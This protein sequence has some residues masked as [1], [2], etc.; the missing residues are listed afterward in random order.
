MI[1]LQEGSGT[2]GRLRCELGFDISEKVAFSEFHQI[3]GKLEENA[4]EDGGYLSDDLKRLRAFFLMIS[5]GP[6]PVGGMAGLPE[7]KNGALTAEMETAL[8]IELLSSCDSRLM[9]K[10]SS[11]VFCLALE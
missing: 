10:F 2:R 3:G 11:V 4:P 9:I 1:S 8:G 5:Q 6:S 7:A